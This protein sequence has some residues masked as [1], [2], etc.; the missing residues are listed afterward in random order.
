MSRATTPHKAHAA[1]AAV[2]NMPGA[3]K[4]MRTR[5][6]TAPRSAGAQSATV[7]A[8]ADYRP[9]AA[10]GARQGR[11]TI[12]DFGDGHR[13]VAVSGS[14]ETDPLSSLRALCATMFSIMQ[15]MESNAERHLRAPSRAHGA[16]YSLRDTQ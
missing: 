14:F 9:S 7:H 6:T 8:L 2:L 1:G 16:E 15:R 13:D 4:P 11:L 12:T 10:P 5:K 3:S